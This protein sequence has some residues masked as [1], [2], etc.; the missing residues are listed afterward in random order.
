MLR[1]D[2]TSER[3]KW[4]KRL[5]LWRLIA[6]MLACSSRRALGRRGAVGASAT[7]VVV[8]TQREFA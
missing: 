2:E 7:A 5:P 1:N 8:S 4:L 6:A 3:R